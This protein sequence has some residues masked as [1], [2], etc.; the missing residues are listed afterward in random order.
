MANASILTLPPELLAEI[1]KWCSYATT[2]A[3]QYTC[4][5]L[6]A[7]AAASKSP[8]AQKKPTGNK[9][10][11]MD[12]L[13]EIE[14]WPCYDF[15]GQNAKNLQCPRPTLDFFACRYCLKIRCASRFSKA[16]TRG[17]RGKRSSTKDTKSRLDRFCIDCGVTFGRYAPGTNFD[18][19]GSRYSDGP[20]GW[21]GF[22]CHRCGEF[23]R[24][25]SKEEFR[26]QK[27]QACLTGTE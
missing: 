25:F 4:R 9:S 7:K 3:L 5:E 8:A 24:T 2:L 15:A 26:R 16:M 12:D 23:K 18:F 17:K 11:T 22:V 6:Y 27:C 13:L 20:G 19:G 1:A 21:W 10:Y 14:K